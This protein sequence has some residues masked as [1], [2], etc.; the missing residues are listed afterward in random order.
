MTDQAP[1]GKQTVVHD[2][3]A[4]LG[5][6]RPQ[7]I[8]MNSSATCGHFIIW[9]SLLKMIYDKMIQPYKHVGTI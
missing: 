2:E 9:G 1:P 8:W 5:K 6:L 4:Q 7:G 3:A